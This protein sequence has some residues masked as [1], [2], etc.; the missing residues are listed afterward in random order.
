[1]ERKES[2]EARWEDLNAATGNGKRRLDSCAV[3]DPI[4][5]V[6]APEKNAFVSRPTA[7]ETWM[8]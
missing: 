8:E 5:I 1:M 2:V 3:M 6:D 7:P 4:I